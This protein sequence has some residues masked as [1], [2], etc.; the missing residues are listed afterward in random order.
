LIGSDLEQ[1]SRHFHVNAVG[2]IVLYQA[3][4]D[5]LVKSPIPR[6]IAISSGAASVTEPFPM[7]ATPYLMSK[8]AL[9]MAVQKIAQEEA[10]SGMVAIALSPG[11][12]CCPCSRTACRP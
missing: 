11:T 1:F 2:P 3:F 10:E 4:R 5:L 8:A 9:N 7:P 6:Y 12:S